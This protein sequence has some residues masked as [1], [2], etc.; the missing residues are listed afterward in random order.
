MMDKEETLRVISKALD[1]GIYPLSTIVDGEEKKRTE[2][3]DGWNACAMQALYDVKKAIGIFEE[4]WAEPDKFFAAYGYPL[5]PK[6]DGGWYILLNDT[7]Y[8]ACS[9]HEEIPQEK[10]MEVLSWI[11]SY[12]WM[13]LIYWVFLQRGHYPEIEIFKKDVE[14][15]EEIQNGKICEK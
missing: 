13:G 4:K 9:D 14:R 8:F 12:G 7:W 1:A 10:E 15:M 11:R 6:K 2:W 5:Y 3:Q